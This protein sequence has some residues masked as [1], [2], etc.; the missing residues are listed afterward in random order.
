MIFSIAEKI[1]EHLTTINN[2][3]VQEKKEEEEKIL[4]EE[5]QIKE[6]FRG[7]IADSKIN[8]IPVT[9]QSFIEWE[10]KFR[11]EMR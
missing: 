3:F 2:K 8:Y 1:K 9:E 4:I 10:T 5:Q 11:Q 7:M 6:T